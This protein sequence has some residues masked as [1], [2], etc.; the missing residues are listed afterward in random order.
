MYPRRASAW[1]SKP[2]DSI[3]ARMSPL[4]IDLR[5]FFFNT[6]SAAVK[7]GNVLVQRDV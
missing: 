7:G 3:A 5:P 1:D 2:F 4:L 6:F